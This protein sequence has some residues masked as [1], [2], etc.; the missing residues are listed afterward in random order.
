MLNHMLK[1]SQN[2][3]KISRNDLQDAK[4]ARLE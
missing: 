1:T 2:M 4:M 3:W